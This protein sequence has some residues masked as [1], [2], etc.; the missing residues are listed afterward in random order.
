MKISHNKKGKK[1]TQINRDNIFYHQRDKDQ[2]LKY[3]ILLQRT[4]L[5]KLR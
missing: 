1:I 4:E 5:Y 3:K 2:T